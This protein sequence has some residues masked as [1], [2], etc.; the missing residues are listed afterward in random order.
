MSGL[1]IPIPSPR[2]G[3]RTAASF[4]TDALRSAILSGVLLDGEPLRQDELAAALGVSR[5]PVREALR[6][7]EAE[8]LVDFQPHKGAVVAELSTDEIDEVYEMRLLAECLV[9]RLSIPFLTEED[10]DR[11]AAISG[12]IEVMDDF[13]RWSQLNRR[14]H[15]TLYAGVARRRLRALISAL[16]DAVDRYHRIL[17]VQSD[18]AGRA[19]DEH[20]QILAACRHRDVEA[21]TSLLSVHISAA[22]DALIG[23]LRRHR[24]GA[25]RCGGPAVGVARSAPPQRQASRRLGEDPL[26]RQPYADERAAP[27]LALDRQPAAM[28]LDER[29]RQRQSEPGAFV[30]PVELA[31]DLPERFE[32]DRDILRPHADP[33][34]LDQDIEGAG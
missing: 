20:R 11:A 5:M 31:L 32:R 12:E 2:P 9:L 25:R 8:G 33:G 15:E 16:N 24:N 7:L 28:Q 26:P 27:R 18:Y 29:V 34:I 30:A 3:F 13:V 22:R 10:F 17:L 21:A 1:S 14:F 23:L 6:R 19:H 4:V